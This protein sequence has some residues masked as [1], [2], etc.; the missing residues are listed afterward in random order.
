MEGEDRQRVLNCC[1]SKFPQRS[2]NNKMG[3]VKC[4]A[5]GERK[6]TKKGEQDG[7]L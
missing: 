3:R 7:C 1:S 2:G 6:I 5:M 4:E